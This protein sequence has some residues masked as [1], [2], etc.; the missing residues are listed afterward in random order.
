MMFYLHTL[1]C[2]ALLF[3]T[4]QTAIECPSTDH[5]SLLL[6]EQDYYYAFHGETVVHAP[7]TEENRISLRCDITIS[8]VKACHFGLHLQRCFSSE[9]THTENKTLDLFSKH[10][11]LFSLVDGE[12]TEI[13]SNEKEPL[14]VLNIKR[15]ILSAFVFKLSHT[16]RFVQE[17]TNDIHGTCP[18]TAVPMVAAKGF[19]KTSRNLLMCNR[20]VKNEEHSMFLSNMKTV[21]SATKCDY[22]I[23]L[24]ER[25]LN[26]VNCTEKHVI[27]NI[28]SIIYYRMTYKSHH[29][30]KR[31]PDFS[32]AT[33]RG[34][35]EF[36]QRQQPRQDPKDF[37]HVAQE[38]LSQLAEHSSDGIRLS[39]ISEFSDLVA[40]LRSSSNLT[41]FLKE[42]QE[43]HYLKDGAD[44]LSKKA[45]G[46]SYL[47][48]ALVYCSSAPCIEA[49]SHLIKSGEFLPHISM[50][51]SWSNM[52]SPDPEI[53]KHIQNICHDTDS[54]WCWMSL[55]KLVQ[56][57]YVKQHNIS[58]SK[59]QL[60]EAVKY[61]NK[62]IE[63]LCASPESDPV[64]LSRNLE[65]IRNMGDAYAFISPNG[66][67]EL[68]ECLLKS[69]IPDDL[70]ILI[71]EVFKSINPY[72]DETSGK[73][74]YKEFSRVLLNSTLS[75]I[76]RIMAYDQI[77]QIPPSDEFGNILLTILKT[78]ENMQLKS[79]IAKSLKTLFLDTNLKSKEKRF[80]K[81]MH[82]LLKREGLS[83]DRI[84]HEA[85]AK[86]TTEN[87]LPYKDLSGIL[88]ELS[89]LSLKMLNSNG[90][91]S[92]NEFSEWN[93]TILLQLIRNLSQIFGF[94]DQ[95]SEKYE[96]LV[97]L[98]QE[99]SKDILVQVPSSDKL[100]KTIEE[101]LKQFGINSKPSQEY[102]FSETILNNIK[103][104]EEMYRKPKESKNF[105]N[106]IS[107]FIGS[108]WHYISTG[109]IFQFPTRI[110]EMR[111]FLRRL[112]EGVYF[113][114]TRM[115]R[116][117]ETR[118]QVPTMMG[119]PLRWDTNAT[120]AF[121]LRSGL[122]MEMQLENFEILLDGFFQPSA[123]LT[124]LNGMAVDLPSV[125][126]AGMQVN[127]SV[128]A[129]TEWKAKLYYSEERKIFS[130]NRPS[131][132]RNIL[133]FFN[134]HRLMK[135]G[136]W[137][138]S[139]DEGKDTSSSCT[140]N[141]LSSLLGLQFCV[142]QSHSK[143]PK[144]NY[145]TWQ[146]F[147]Q[148]SDKEVESY[149]VEILSPREVNHDETIIKYSTLGS[150]KRRDIFFIVCNGNSL[151]ETKFQFTLPAIPHFNFFIQNLR[152][153]RNYKTVMDLTLYK[154][155]QYE[156]IYKA[157]YDM[158]ESSSDA[159]IS[160][161][162]VV[163]ERLLSFRTPFNNYSITFT[164]YGKNEIESTRVI[165]LYSS[166]NSDNEWLHGI[167]PRSFWESDTT[168]WL[169]IK[170]F[171]NAELPQISQQTICYIEDPQ[172][173]TQL[174]T[175]ALHLDGGE[176]Q[177]ICASKRQ[178]SS[179][180]SLA[181]A[182]FTYDF[183][184]LQSDDMNEVQWT[185]MFNL[186]ITQQS[187]AIT[188]HN[189]RKGGKL[190]YEV[191]LTRT[192]VATELRDICN[193][194]ASWSGRTLNIHYT[195]QPQLRLA[196]DV[197][198]QVIGSQEL[199]E[200][201]STVKAQ[202][203]T[204]HWNQLITA[205]FSF[206]YPF[207]SGLESVK[208]G[209]YVIA[210]GGPKTTRFQNT[211]E[212]ESSY[213]NLQLVS[214]SVYKSEEDFFSLRYNSC[215]T[216]I[217]TNKKAFHSVHFWLSTPAG[218][219]S[220]A[221]FNH[222][223]LSRIFDLS[224]IVTYRCKPNQKDLHDLR[225]N[226][227]SNSS[228]WNMLNLS[229]NQ[230]VEDQTPEYT[231]ETCNVTHPL[232]LINVTADWV[233]EMRDHKKRALFTCRQEN[234]QST[235]LLIQALHNGKKAADLI[236]PDGSKRKKLS[237]ERTISTDAKTQNCKITFSSDKESDSEGLH[238]KGEIINENYQVWNLNLHLDACAQIYALFRNGYQSVLHQITSIAKDARHPV[239]K[240]FHSS[241][242]TTL[243]Q[244]FEGLSKQSNYIL[245]NAWKNFEETI[246]SLKPF[247]EDPIT[248]L[249]NVMTSCKTYFTVKDD[250]IIQSITSYLD[251]TSY[252]YR[253]KDTIYQYLK[254]N[255]KVLELEFVTSR[256][257]K[258][259]SFNQWPSISLNEIHI[260]PPA[261]QKSQGLAKQNKI[262]MIINSS[263]IFR[264]DEH[265]YVS[266]LG[267][268]GCVFLLAKDIHQSTF[269]VLSA[270]EMIHVL[271]RDMTI[272][273]S[274]ENKVFINESRISSQLP[275]ET[276]SGNIQVK[277]DKT[278]VEIQSSFLA[279]NCSVQQT[280]HLCVLQ[281]EGLRNSE[282]FGL[283]E[284]ANEFDGKEFSV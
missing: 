225:L 205:N 268:L 139:K 34:G 144:S 54:R 164:H 62:A 240:M 42:I 229:I 105:F 180:K 29:L 200:K 146:A 10:P 5:E 99:V 143:L 176:R 236:I 18:M 178:S 7:D 27:D 89:K 267:S 183:W 159:K 210:S 125:A 265:L 235:E 101:V 231:F 188:L 39:S 38:M 148:P 102:N 276:R 100:L 95:N 206:Y 165:L 282:T 269:I 80:N 221:E 127:R 167:L 128:F 201:Y 108:S 171:W 118:Q 115:I 174:S 133:Q 258:L 51:N 33:H 166:S 76:L 44:C 253:M 130:F 104:L 193:Y 85:Q 41:A 73:E 132:S 82:K 77:I 72:R 234:C 213:H 21:D 106:K 220:E 283:L 37:E 12:I 281:L 242:K 263:H 91:K 218:E 19:V 179:G 215:F 173:T 135:N 237:L 280:S 111:A 152:G 61:F 68:M 232:L 198:M 153:T 256:I 20:T 64:S 163:Q 243:Y 197:E 83:L 16:K 277:E 81:V 35:I 169:Q 70:K 14:H 23:N 113:N 57:I 271:F 124:Y 67:K 155:H 123:A 31:K 116:I 56:R 58:E 182:H 196:V 214:H 137:Y 90:G 233:G 226:L 134:T 216:N 46:M 284:S 266:V 28:Q 126:Q 187:W 103:K 186:T 170:I 160:E 250:S 52:L 43:K 156:L 273:V 11:V 270:A 65:V 247:Y 136:I 185:Q 259:E 22:T 6:P 1:F 177:Y 249:L 264:F 15:G 278:S 47:T 194:V 3:P 260:D 40:W 175:G 203:L 97:T 25:R 224:T 228:D 110:L 149:D 227:R 94:G 131:V 172:S 191:A 157:E 230:L 13:Y 158:K 151:G 207:V 238:L 59:E 114:T 219:C 66:C 30:Q 199:A 78:E 223:I 4:I 217:P 251:F 8:Y 147:L 17:I 129:S 53:L 154:G 122:K 192:A 168:A 248:L 189:E 244:Y 69:Y 63:F 212:V 138:D 74:M 120:L 181:V 92:S 239:N 222:T 32:S 84:I 9:G 117:V 208:G 141:L 145:W 107:D 119:L 150:G 142:L 246:G 184:S 98:L 93:H 272:S 112:E 88:H 255:G 204:G 87:S 262:A 109:E 190:S 261:R 254:P 161:N 241:L 279:V 48:D 71:S 26:Q 274:K 252:F 24:D 257:M 45:I 195:E 55:G 2:I 121:S 211:F 50:F 96:T 162:D 79:Y 202:D 140:N 275:V 86:S 36:E 245:L 75:T 49:I 60:F 209:G